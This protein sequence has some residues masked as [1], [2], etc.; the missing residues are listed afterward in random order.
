[1]DE[2]VDIVLFYSSASLKDKIEVILNHYGIF[3][4]M[5]EEH[6][7]DM[8]IIIKNECEFVKKDDMSALGV[9]TSMYD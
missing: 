9:R 3:L 2:I 8:R 5:I 7:T 4:E 1:M 6:K